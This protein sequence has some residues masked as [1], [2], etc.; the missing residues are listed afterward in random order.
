M[1]ALRGL[2]GTWNMAELQD[3]LAEPSLMSPEKS[4]STPASQTPVQDMG[5]LDSSGTTQPTTMTP[6]ME[7][8]SSPFTPAGGYDTGA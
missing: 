3:P 1:G 5:K 7:A 4:G 6:E 2:K 8:V